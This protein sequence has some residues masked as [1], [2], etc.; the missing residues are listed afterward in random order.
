MRTSSM[1]SLLAVLVMLASSVSVHAGT[2]ETGSAN[3]FIEGSYLVR[4]KEATDSAP[5]LI[6]PPLNKQDMAGSPPPVW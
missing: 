5:S 3:E 2:S 1:V 4:F 6:L